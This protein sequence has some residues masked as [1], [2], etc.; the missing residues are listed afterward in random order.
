LGADVRITVRR[1]GDGVV[2]KVTNTVPAG[3]GQPGNGMALDNVRQRLLLLHD[4]HGRIDQACQDGVFQVRLEIPLPT[5][6]DGL[7]WREVKQ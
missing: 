2:I 7:L 3:H 5:P 1:E 4:M 6:S